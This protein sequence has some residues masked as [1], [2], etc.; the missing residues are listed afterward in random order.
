VS[1]PYV[2]IVRALALVALASCASHG[3]E[4]IYPT[5]VSIGCLQISATRAY[6]ANRDPPIL[7]WHVTNTC[8]YA[9]PIDLAQAR[10][11]AVDAL[12]ARTEL[13]PRD[14]RAPGWIEGGATKSMAVVYTPQVATRDVAIEIEMNAFF[15]LSHRPITL[16][17]LPSV[18]MRPAQ[19][20]VTAASDL[21]AS[22]SE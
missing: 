15:E 13:V 17:V 18:P 16:A 14:R 4:L 3:L 6:D 7:E 2:R 10:V 5:L 19:K 20:S 11:F 12:F 21:S 1:G 9:V 22:D 8:D